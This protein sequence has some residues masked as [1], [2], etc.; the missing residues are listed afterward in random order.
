VNLIF[1]GG[2]EL[3]GLVLSMV[4][5]VWLSRAVG[6]AYFGYYAVMVT[7]VTLG[8]LLINGGLPTA[9]S[10]RV[11]NDPGKAGE[12]LWAVAVTRTVTA[13]IGVLGGLVVLA[14]FPV[15]QILRGYLQVGL[16]TWAL[17]PLSNN[18]V[19][20]A[21]ARL[22]A[23]SVLRVA[24]SVSTFLAA[25][26]LVRDVSQASRVAWIPVVGAIV[27]AVGSNLLAYRRSPYRRP[28]GRRVMELVRSYLRDGLH[29]LKAD[30]SATIFMSSDRL[31][32]YV[33]AT[34]T[35]VGLYAA[36]Y[37]VI[38]PFYAFG[39]VVWDVMYVPV[40]R[41]YGTDRLKSTYRRF[42]D[43][44]CLPAIPLGFFLLAF[45]SPVIAIL[46]GT[47]YAGAGDY[48]AILGWV[49]T[50]GSTSGMAAI[51]FSVWNRPREFGNS[52]LFGG[53]VNLALNF[54][55]IPSF[56][57][58]GAAWA[59]VA[60]KVAITI[61]G[62][63]YFRRA[64]DYPL[65]RDLIEYLALSAVALTAAVAATRFLPYPAASGMVVFGVVYLAL[66]A[67]VRWRDQGP[68]LLAALRSLRPF[69]SGAD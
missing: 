20:V 46:Y 18:W 34:P 51:A 4:T 1:R 52:L 56:G 28:A 38:Q 63:R 43:L 2:A 36:A 41:A 54:A 61:V 3:T 6:P 31:F 42:V 12:V 69:R 21:Q 39:G 33:F 27:G 65:I 19:L 17:L 40:A 62:I 13:A 68:L 53:A 47:K 60:A 32:L 14:L 64:T 58:L 15:D 66:V 7:I 35:V 10:Q 26:L 49:I 16:V 59:T 30:L 37:S 8:S 55:L 24:G 23:V 67:V 45:A 50:F 22:R 5:T 25:V 57:G 9:G 44:S 29:Y 48:L 11:V